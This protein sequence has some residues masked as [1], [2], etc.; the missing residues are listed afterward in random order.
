MSTR[1]SKTRRM[2]QLSILLALEVVIALVPALGSIPI[3]PIVATTAHI[4]VILAAVLLGWK[5][6]ALLGFSFGLLSFL[7][8]SFITPTITSFVFT[9]FVSVGTASGNAW[10]LVICFVPRI[11]LGIIAGLLY[12]WLSRYDGKDWWS[13]LVAAVTGTVMHTLLVLFGIYLF[14]GEQYAAANGIGFEALLYAIGTVILT[15]GVPEAILAA[16]IAVAVARPVKKQLAKR[17]I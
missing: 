2:V 16:V 8:H 9:P 5:A 6:G 12:Q 15:N 4:P 11:L 10:S 1:S 14:F 3:G 17:H 7:V 13:Y